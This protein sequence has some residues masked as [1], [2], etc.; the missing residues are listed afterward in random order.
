MFFYSRTRIYRSNRS[1]NTRCED[2]RNEDYNN[3]YTFDVYNT[4]GINSRDRLFLDGEFGFQ[5]KT[6]ELDLQAR[7]VFSRALSLCCLLVLRLRTNKSTNITI[8]FVFINLQTNID[9]AVPI[10]IFLFSIFT[11]HEQ[12]SVL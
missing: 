4:V 1:F 11:K 6:L 10:K 2:R 7:G 5:E 3:Y 9:V 12:N 8:L